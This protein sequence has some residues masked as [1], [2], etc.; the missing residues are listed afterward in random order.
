MLRKIF[1]LSAIS[2]IAILVFGCNGNGQ[3]QMQMPPPTVIVTDAAVEDV[4]PSESFIGKVDAAVKATITARVNGFLEKRL[5]KE[6][7]SVK[8]D[9]LLFTIEKSQYVAAVKQA[10]G[11][12][13]QGK[14]T[15]ENARL[16][17]ERGKALLASASIS[18][19]KYDD[20][21]AADAAAR[22]N[23]EA[24]EAALAA[25]NV[26]LAYTDVMS[27]VAGK[28]GFINF[29]IGETVGPSVGAL[30]TVIAQEPMYVVFSVTDRQMQTLR[31]K[32]GGDNMTFSQAIMTNANVQLT[33]SDGTKYPII[34]KINFTDNTLAGTTDSLRV[35]A[36]FANPQGALTQGQTVTVYLR[37]K[38][39][40]KNV[41]VPQMAIINDVGG[42]Y[43]LVV[44]ANNN[45][46]HTNVVL[47]EQLEGGKQVIQ[48]GLKGGE[49]V[50]IEG[51][52]KVRPNTPV[53]AMTRDQ[54]NQMIQQQ[55]QKAQ[56]P[57]Q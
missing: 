17:K 30:T 20:L 50:I 51:A 55:Q 38:G 40:I 21:T 42:R 3:Q 49:R 33:L 46:I 43:V 48:S 19:A 11:A 37:S 39:A 28:V 12:L 41:V 4:T 57:Q 47:G 5:V 16:Q 29:N 2:S 9:Q 7:D 31:S 8:Q 44:D 14:A 22:A 35:R 10:E 15:A 53:N 18:Q 6:G 26:N 25:A 13:A 52:Q 32:Y 34:G 36:E 27:P 56:Q 1:L 45:V 24:Y 23:V 54:Y